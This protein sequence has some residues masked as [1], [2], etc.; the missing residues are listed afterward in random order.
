MEADQKCD[1][2]RVRCYFLTPAEGGRKG[3]I[4]TTA[5]IKYRPNARIAGTPL[6]VQFS[7]WLAE[8]PTTILLGDTVD[9][10]WILASSNDI[11]YSDFQVGA[12]I[13]IM[14]G[15]RVVARG[16]ILERFQRSLSEFR[17]TIRGE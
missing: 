15:R 2:I 10:D 9:C 7:T 16:P 6:D 13:E 8:R 12:T 14:E 3:P 5:E 4:R 11:P 17:K 1:F